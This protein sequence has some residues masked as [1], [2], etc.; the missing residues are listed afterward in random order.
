MPWFLPAVPAPLLPN[1][2][3]RLNCTNLLPT[4]GKAVVWAGLLRQFI[5]EGKEEKVKK[6]F[7]RRAVLAA[8]LS[9]GCK[10]HAGAAENG[11]VHGHCFFY[12]HVAYF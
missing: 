12:N 11:G 8:F 1:N 6:V 3:G 10:R 7:V 9:H 4:L 5:R 2:Q